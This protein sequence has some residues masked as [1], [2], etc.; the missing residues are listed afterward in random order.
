M[1]A[2]LKKTKN[3]IHLFLLW[4]CQVL[5]AAVGLFSRCGEWPSHP[6]GLSC[7]RAQAVDTGFSR[8]TY[9]EVQKKKKK[10]NEWFVDRHM[11]KHTWPRVN[12]I[13]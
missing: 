13:I 8:G 2:T 4:L 7:C 6:S 11:T 3:K 5:V 1:L 9:F 12:G 10:V